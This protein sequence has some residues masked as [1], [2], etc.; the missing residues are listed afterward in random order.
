MRCV[1]G[2]AAVSAVMCA[3]ALAGGCAVE[4]PQTGTGES[5][6]G[7]EELAPVEQSPD[8]VAPGWTAFETPL[9]GMLVPLTYLS[10]RG[11]PRIDD[12]T[13]L[14]TI[15]AQQGGPAGVLILGMY[16]ASADVAAHP[17]AAYSRC[18]TD[19]ECAAEQDVRLPYWYLVAVQRDRLA[20]GSVSCPSCGQLWQDELGIVSDDYYGYAQNSAL[21]V[22]FVAANAVRLPPNGLPEQPCGEGKVLRARVTAAKV[23]GGAENVVFH[24][25]EGDFEAHQSLAW[26]NGICGTTDYPNSTTDVIDGT[27]LDVLAV[28]A[29]R[30]VGDETVA[31]PAYDARS[32]YG[33]LCSD[34]DAA[35]GR[36]VYSHWATVR[37]GIGLAQHEGRMA[38]FFFG[39]MYCADAAAPT[40]AE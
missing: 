40:A 24:R 28:N 38:G 32:P 3:F 18:W 26:G 20:E 25:G 7:G 31:M 21:A 14:S 17:G 16:N 37:V 9:A 2:K 33:V 23:A 27:W 39:S 6:L 4:A 11:L 29:E 8:F 30:P 10:F 12:G 36:D 34:A 35:A 13:M 5:H 15:N 19:D 1:I 22:G